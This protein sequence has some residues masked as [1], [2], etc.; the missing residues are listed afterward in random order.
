VRYTRSHRSTQ[1]SAGGPSNKRLAASFTKV[2]AT[3]SPKLALID[4]RRRARAS[5]VGTNLRTRVRSLVHAVPRRHHAWRGGAAIDLRQPQPLRQ[6]TARS[7][8]PR[9]WDACVCTRSRASSRYLEW[10]VRHSVGTPTLVAIIAAPGRNAAIVVRRMS[11]TPASR[12][13]ETVSGVGASQAPRRQRPPRVRHPTLC[14][15][16]RARVCLDQD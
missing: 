11:A 6:P 7:R 2:G 9:D 14:C 15:G 10:P 16:P 3:R 5:R 12:R 8:F 4:R 1:C 13:S